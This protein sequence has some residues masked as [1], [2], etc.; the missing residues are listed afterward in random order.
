MWMKNTNG[1]P[2]AMLTIAMIA[3]LVVVLNIILATFG[4]VTILG[5]TLTFVAMDSG[6]LAAFL[7][8]TL[9]AYVTR[10]WTSAAYP[11]NGGAGEE[12]KPPEGFEPGEGSA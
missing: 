10:R 4:T 3:F 9:G 12:P 6:T 8:P 7:T 5:T 2:D 11:K 1:K